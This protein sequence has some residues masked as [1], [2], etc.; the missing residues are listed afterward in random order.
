MTIFTL[1]KLA[2]SR[3]PETGSHL[4]RM[5]EYCRVL[6]ARLSRKKKYSDTIDAD[7]VHLIYLT[8]PCMTSARW[9]FRTAFF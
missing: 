9:E 6:A 7:Y 8:S 1:A 3:S 2:E 5:R 4:E